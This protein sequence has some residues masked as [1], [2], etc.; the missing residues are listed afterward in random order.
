MKWNAIQVAEDFKKNGWLEYEL[1]DAV[2]NVWKNYDEFKYLFQDGRRIILPIMATRILGY[3][4]KEMKFIP[5]EIDPIMDYL[6]G[7]DDLTNADMVRCEG[8]NTIYKFQYNFI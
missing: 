4:D 6:I 5:K 7:N 3:D 1:I 2:I 8:K